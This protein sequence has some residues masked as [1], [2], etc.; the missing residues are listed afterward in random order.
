MADVG[1]L[2]REKVVQAN[3]VMAFFNQPFAQ[4]GTQKSGPTGDCNA[5]NFLGHILPSHQPG[6]QKYQTDFQD[7]GLVPGQWL[8]RGTNSE[9]NSGL[10]KPEFLQVLIFHQNARTASPLGF[11]VGI[12]A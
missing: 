7:S 12:I 1:L 4:M 3:D 6:S 2:G 5:S 8:S 9:D 10:P 11:V